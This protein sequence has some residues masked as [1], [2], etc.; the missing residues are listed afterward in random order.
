[1]HLQ[2]NLVPRWLL[3]K[4]QTRPLA[5]EPAAD[6]AAA[7][8]AAANGA[9]ALSKTKLTEATIQE[10]VVGNTAEGSSPCVY[11]DDTGKDGEVTQLSSCVCF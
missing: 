2:S 10:A 7:D 8:E 3:S 4:P 11:T 9:A 5:G 6:K 1:M